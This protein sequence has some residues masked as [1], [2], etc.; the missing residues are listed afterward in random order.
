MDFF[1]NVR[2]SWSRFW[3]NFFL[4]MSDPRV[5]QAMQSSESLLGQ[6]HPNTDQPKK[7]SE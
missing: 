3:K 7:P 6:S 4:F 1:K 5:L 2:E